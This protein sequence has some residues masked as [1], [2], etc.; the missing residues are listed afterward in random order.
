MPPWEYWACSTLLLRMLKLSLA[1][2]HMLPCVNQV[3]HHGY[4]SWTEV[5]RRLDLF[6]VHGDCCITE[7]NQNIL[8]NPS[9]YMIMGM[10]LRKT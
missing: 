6:A 1:S 10:P 5:N 4:P 7:A 2:F 3:I 8:L 9:H